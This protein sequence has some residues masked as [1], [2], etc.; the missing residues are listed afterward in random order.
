M[1]LGFILVP[2]TFILT[3]PSADYIKVAPQ[4]AEIITYMVYLMRAFLIFGLLHIIRKTLLD[5][6]SA[7]INKL[8]KQA[9]EDKQAGL[10]LVAIAVMILGFCILLAA[11][12]MP[13]G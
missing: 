11:I 9:I 1:I 12:V 10:A 4:Y 8:L 3:N 2:I 13:A 6:D 5:Y 7:D